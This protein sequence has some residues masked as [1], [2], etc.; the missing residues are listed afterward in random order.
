[1]G[2]ITK[3]FDLGRMAIC[4]FLKKSQDTLPPHG[5][6]AFRLSLNPLTLSFSGE[7]EQAYLDDF[8]NKAL[9]QVRMI[10]LMGIF[11]FGI[12]DAKLLPG[13]KSTLWFIRYAIVTPSIISVIVFSF[14]SQFKRYMQLCLTLVITLSGLGI[15]IMIL[16]APPPV[17]YSYYAGLIL[18]L[19]FGYVFLRIR[20][21]WASIAGWAIVAFYEIAAIWLSS[22]PVTILFNNNFFF[23][24]ANFIGMFA[25]YSIEYY[26]RRDFYLVKLLEIEQKKVNAANL[27][28]EERV[29]VRTSQ[30]MKANEELTFEIEAHRKAEEEKRELEHQL[31]QAQKMEAIGTLAGGIAHDFNNILSPIIG[32]S[33]MIMDDLQKQNP[34][35]NKIEQILIAATRAKDLVKHIL[36]F[37]RQTEQ[38][39]TPLEI[40]SIIKESLKLLRAS[41]PSTIEI[42]QKID[43]SCRPVLADPTQIHQVIMN[44]CTNAFHA[45]R[46]KGGTLGVEIT[47]VEISISDCISLKLNPG[48]Y[49]R[50]SVSDTGHGIPASIMDRI[51]EPYFT[52]KAPGEGTGLGLSVV[53]GIVKSYNGDIKIYSEPGKGTSVNIYLPCIEADASIREK[54]VSEVISSGRE[55][56]LLVDDEEYIIKMMKEMIERLG[57]RI[58]AYT[59]S[60]IAYDE[61]RMNPYEYD[62][63]ITDQTMPDMV[64]TELAKE[65]MRI[66]PNIPVIIC[67]GFSE[68]LS[69]EKA[70]AIGIR[71]YISKP[72]VKSEISK[73]I[74]NVLDHGNS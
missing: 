12:L 54:S 11:F 53:H 25:C 67:T 8:F 58:S 57:Y 31:R 46:D 55:R 7:L 62:L 68:I 16:I 3:G 72:V 47:E 33:E 61:F 21:I 41:L 35:K 39:L 26:S 52:T 37:S 66:R 40:Q 44:L 28:L 23:I 64:G 30:L 10:L 22:T 45:M 59:S 29:K 60:R 17:N 70:K 71:E 20:F 65:L 19:I 51:F 50:I 73:A 2:S 63:V 13:S 43:V 42:R 1:M 36:T 24:S 6:E 14:S 5:I 56:I 4:D 18:V 15:I 48:I 34:M 38:E 49:V 74:R 27:E 32:Y 69:E 9:K